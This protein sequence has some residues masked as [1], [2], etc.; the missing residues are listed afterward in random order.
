M[1]GCSMAGDAS[2][3]AR[4]VED[5]WHGSW[6][7]YVNASDPD[8]SPSHPAQAALLRDLFGNP[9]RP[10]GIAG[11]WLTPDV[12]ALA[13]AIYDGRLFG[14][15]PVLADALEEAGC[16]DRELVAHLRGPGPHVLG[17]WALDAVLGK[18]EEPPSPP[19]PVDELPPF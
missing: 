3:H 15:L 5:S 9:F 8:Y 17:C 11:P 14:N 18:H 12:A 4:D 16:A 19:A 13:Q 10:V 6:G 2:L 1:R 7:R